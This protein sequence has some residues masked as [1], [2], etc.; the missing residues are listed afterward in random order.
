MPEGSP[1]RSPASS[2]LIPSQQLFLQIIL[3]NMKNKLE[4]DW[5]VIAEKA[6]YKS[7]ESA[8]VTFY[9]IMSK[10]SG[11]SGRDP[12]KTSSS[13]GYSANTKSKT[14]T[15]RTS[16]PS[17]V[18]KSKPVHRK[19]KKAKAERE[20]ESSDETE[21]RFEGGRDTYALEPESM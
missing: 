4:V 16:F 20:S 7:G 5:A 15:A 14:R 6:G 19:N 2:K 11:K 18:T 8:R 10:L 1:N 12:L 3:S 9:Q 21:Q 13:T 17:K